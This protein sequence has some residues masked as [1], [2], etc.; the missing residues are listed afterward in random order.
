MNYVEEIGG[1]LPPQVDKRRAMRFIAGNHNNVKDAYT[2]MHETAQWRAETFPYILTRNDK[3]LLESGYSY[4]HGRDKFLRPILINNP[5]VIADTGFDVQECFDMGWF[6]IKYA[7]DNMFVRGRVENIVMISD[8]TGFSSSS[9]PTSKIQEFFKK[10][11]TH[12]KCRLRFQSN[13]NVNW[14]L[15]TLWMIVKNFI[16]ARVRNKMELIGGTKSKKLLELAHESQVEEKYGGTAPDVIKY[17]PPYC[18]SEE[19]GIDPDCIREDLVVEK[20]E[21]SSETKWFTCISHIDTTAEKSEGLA[22]EDFL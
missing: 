5:R 11:Q 14:K 1:S 13:L 21:V 3:I 18:P 7:M 20:S 19:Y 15:R 2:N 6:V 16:D 12:L 8:L 17:W 22:T 9:I 10:F 4:I